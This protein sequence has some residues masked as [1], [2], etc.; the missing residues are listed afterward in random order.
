VNACV[1]CGGKFGLIR[2]KLGVMIWE[3]QFC[4]RKCLESHRKELQQAERVRQFLAW[5]ASPQTPR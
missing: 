2:R 4:S 5:L 3:K 1:R